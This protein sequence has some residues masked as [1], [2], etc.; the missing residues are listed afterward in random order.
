MNQVDVAHL[1]FR[2]PFAPGSYNRLVGMQIEQITG[3]RQTA[4]CYWDQPAPNGAQTHGS[5]TLVDANGLSLRQKLLLNLPAK[6]LMRRFNNITD[7]KSLIYLWQALKILPEIKPSVIV[8]YDTYKFGPLLRRA[9]DWPCRLVFSQHGLSYHL[10][11]NEAGHLYSLDS[12]DAVWA[13]TRSAYRFERYRVSAYEPLVK[14]LPNWINVEEFKPVSESGKKERRAKWKLPE[15]SLIV[16]WLSRLVPK[17]GAHAILESWLKIKREI[18]NAFLWIVGG[19]DHKYE[20]YLK[21]IVKNLAIEDSVRIQ[22]AVAPEQTVFCY[23]ASDLY[24]FPT[25]FSGEGFGLSLLEAMACGLPC[26]AS[27]H[28]VLQEL[29]PGDAVSLV[30]DANIAGAFVEP[31]VNLLRD[32][33][34]RSWMGN[35]AREFVEEN[36]N[37]KKALREVEEFYREQISLAGGVR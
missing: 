31:I 24:V 18:P 14:V 1:S 37:H 6:T 36:Y 15:D 7:R 4:I 16:L 27:D 26:V 3:L 30:P 28:V 35:A 23:Q 8:C 9:V 32:A 29:Y 33:K 25:L 17:K 11:P 21:G 22:G 13:L 12:F 34:S 10:T 19:G 2:P 20:S 5:L